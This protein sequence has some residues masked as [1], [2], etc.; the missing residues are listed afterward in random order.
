MEQLRFRIFTQMFENN[1]RVSGVDQ[2]VQDDFI[3][4]CFRKTRQHPNMLIA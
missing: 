2:F 3:L 1:F 4:D